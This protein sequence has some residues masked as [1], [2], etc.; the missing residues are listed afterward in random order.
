M[1]GKKE[2]VGKNWQDICNRQDKDGRFRVF[3]QDIFLVGFLCG[4]VDAPK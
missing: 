3:L 4:I 1:W 2:S